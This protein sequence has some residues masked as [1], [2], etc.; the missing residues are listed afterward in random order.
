MS[1]HTNIHGSFERNLRVGDPVLDGNTLFIWRLTSKSLII[2]SDPVKWW[3]TRNFWLRIAHEK[4]TC[5]FHKCR[6]SQRKSISIW[7]FASQ[8]NS[9]PITRSSKK[10]GNKI[11]RNQLHVEV[12]SHLHIK[13]IC[14]SK[15]LEM[16]YMV[17]VV[18][19]HQQEV[20]KGLTL[21]LISSQ[22]R[23]RGTW[24]PGEHEK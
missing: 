14:W 15:R 13:E 7:S 20:C 6:R 12:I 21:E 11:F 18:V 2:A 24:K 9:T 22:V 4:G 19:E 16:P 3:W 1:S 23:H 10:W 17:V 5:S 8:E